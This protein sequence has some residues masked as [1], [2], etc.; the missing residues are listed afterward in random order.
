MLPRLDIIA[1]KFLDAK[2]FSLFFHNSPG[3]WGITNSIEGRN[4]R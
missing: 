4:T 3:F 1:H 2:D